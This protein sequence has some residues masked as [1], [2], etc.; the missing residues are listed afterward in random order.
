MTKRTRK[1]TIKVND[2]DYALFDYTPFF[3][4]D[5]PCDDYKTSYKPGDV[6]VIKEKDEN[7]EHTVLRVGVVLGCID[8]VREEL[9][10]DMSG[11]V[12]YDQIEPYHPIKHKDVELLPK[13]FTDLISR[14]HIKPK[15]KNHDLK[16]EIAKH[17][18]ADDIKLKID[19][20]DN[21]KEPVYYLDVNDTGYSYSNSDDALHDLELM[22]KL[23][24]N[25]HSYDKKKAINN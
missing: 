22:Q 14:G 11:M 1:T 18:R 24:K 7:E 25:H 21:S 12:C 17:F 23:I 15:F 2:K 3:K 6:V 5:E 13:L 8:E 16:F 20:N 19:I 4:E 10:T 9:R